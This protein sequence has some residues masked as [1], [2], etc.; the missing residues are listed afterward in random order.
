MLWKGYMQ[1]DVLNCNFLSNEGDTYIFYNNENY[2]IKT[3]IYFAVME[4]KPLWIKKVLSYQ[5][6]GRR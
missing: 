2:T 1:L 4:D 5:T 3:F 6:S